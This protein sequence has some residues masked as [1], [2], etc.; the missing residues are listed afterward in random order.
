MT[1]RLRLTAAGL[2]LCQIAV[3]GTT[4]LRR[5]GAVRIL[6]L[7][8]VGVLAV[9]TAARLAEPD[10]LAL[11]DL[12]AASG[13][14]H[15]MIHA[16]LLAVFAHS[17]QPGRTPLVTILARRIRGPLV[18]EIARY[19]RRVTQAWCLFFGGQLVVSAGLFLFAPVSVWSLFVNVLDGPSVLLMF[20][21]EYAVRRVHLRDQP[22]MSPLALV[23]RLAAGGPT[24]PEQP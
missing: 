8:A 19:T 1:G 23:R 3:V 6:G 17:L 15:M 9:L 14:S 21:A 11:P 10:R 16:S 7:A 22:H 13:L 12:L 2:A 18:P 4:V 24:L 20:A 5:G